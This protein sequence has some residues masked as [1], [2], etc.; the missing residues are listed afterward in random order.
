MP[1]RADVAQAVGAAFVEAMDPVA[2]RLAI[3]AAD[4]GGLPAVHPIDDRGQRQQTPALVGVRRGCRQTPK[5]KSRVIRP[6]FHRSSH[7]AN[8]PRAMA[9]ANA[10]AGKTPRVR[11]DGRWYYS[12]IVDAACDAWNRLTD[13]PDI[14]TSIGMRDGTQ[15]GQK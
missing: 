7:G 1:L 13:R 10:A 8:P 9:A 15:I 14:I 3:H 5:V 12:D 11:M 2:K 4:T 6:K